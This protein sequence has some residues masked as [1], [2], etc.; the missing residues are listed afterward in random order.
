MADVKDVRDLRE[1][2]LLGQLLS[3][4]GRGRQ[5]EAADLIAMRIREVRMAKR[6]GGS[7][8]KAGVL[9]LL[10]GGHAG[11]AVIPDGALVL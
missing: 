2:H 3:H 11:T 4:L 7:W 9:S 1:C 6:D 5:A 8:E 10:P